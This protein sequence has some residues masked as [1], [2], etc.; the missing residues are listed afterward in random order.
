METTLKRLVYLLPF[1]GV[2]LASF[3]LAAPLYTPWYNSDH[4]VHVL[5]VE[6][7]D[8]SSDW[9]YWGQDRLGSW[10]PLF[11]QLFNK[12]FQFNAIWSASLA[13]YFT[14]IFGFYFFQ[15]FLK[16]YS[17]KVVLCLAYFM[18][19][20]L[21]NNQVFLGHPYPGQLLFIGVTLYLLRELRRAKSH[22]QLMISSFAL[23]LC[24]VGSVWMSDI[25]LALFPFYLIFF[26]LDKGK[27]DS[28]EEYL[29]WKVKRLDFAAWY[30]VVPLLLSLFLGNTLLSSAKEGA[31]SDPRYAEIFANKNEIRQAIVLFLNSIQ[32][33]LMFRVNNVLVSFQT[34]VFCMALFVGLFFSIKMKDKSKQL[35]SY[36]F[37]GM[38]FF[39]LLLL[40]A[41]NW[42][43]L[44][45]HD[46]RYFTI[47]Y[48]LFVCGLC[49]L[50]DS[51]EAKIRKVGI[52]F[53]SLAVVL[54]SIHFTL[55]H[56]K[57][58]SHTKKEIRFR[59][60]KEE[61]R[62][63]PPCTLIGTYWN[64]YNL[65]S[66]RPKDIIAVPHD[67][68]YARN[69]GE[70]GAAFRREEIFLISNDW[71]EDYP[72]EIFQRGYFLKKSGEPFKLDI[73]TYCEYEP[74]QQ[75]SLTNFEII[76]ESLKAK[77]S[78]FV[79]DSTHL[80]A[81]LKTE[82]L[83]LSKG[84]YSFNFDIRSDEKVLMEGIVYYD[85]GKKNFLVKKLI[86]GENTLNFSVNQEKGIF[87][88]I[89][90]KGVGKAKV[91]LGHVHKDI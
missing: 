12:V 2:I 57:D 85:F 73:Y 52:V 67:G 28:G 53:L 77:N 37:L 50:W 38:T 14:L 3:F 81:K 75:F 9:F 61:A 59:V 91:K 86:Q 11:G 60:L 55:S 5:M 58:F 79:K 32:E 44:F 16:S 4:A 82:Y 71:L 68:H 34:L 22:R 42:V 64:G 90:L 21:F 45:R 83:Q 56:T 43:N 33:S 10:I 49:Y 41:S 25:S 54:G 20:A 36:A 8:W 51:L 15:S 1:L 78:Y 23:G 89:K 18:P 6:K 65:A 76:S 39:L 17:L 30:C 27:P 24:F 19:L 40:L 7:F 46:L 29:A 31:I 88:M 13:L 84:N 62:N 70:L 74:V 69:L 87:L 72:S 35:R 80:E 63:L 47:V 48:I 26:L 66:T